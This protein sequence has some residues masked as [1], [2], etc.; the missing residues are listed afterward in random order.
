MINRSAVRAIIN[1]ELDA[2][3]LRSSKLNETLTQDEIRLLRNV[4]LTAQRLDE[5]IDWFSL[6]ATALSSVAGRRILI[7]LLKVVRNI[8]GTKE[9][10]LRKIHD[11]VWDKAID[12]LTGIGIELP[13][14]GET[15]FSFI[16]Y[17]M[18][19]T[20]ANMAIDELINVLGDMSDSEYQEIVKNK[21]KD[22]DE[23]DEDSAEE[24]GDEEEEEPR[25]AAEGRIRALVRRELAKLS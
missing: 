19:E 17:T 11:S 3:L 13:F 15:V 25:V 24:E 9:V 21:S 18:P 23:S 1:E 22:E 10:V 14:S 5:Q 12:R 2:A 16:R 7:A 4:S 20:Y 8:L 6:G